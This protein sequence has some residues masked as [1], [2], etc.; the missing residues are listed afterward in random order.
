[1]TIGKMYI[2]RLLKK[3][4]M[5]IWE[6]KIFNKNTFNNPVLCC[7]LGARLWEVLGKCQFN[8]PLTVFL[9]VWRI[10]H[11][12]PLVLYG[13]MRLK[14]LDVSNDKDIYRQRWNIHTLMKASPTCLLLIY[15]AF[16]FKS[17]NEN[18][19]QTH[20]AKEQNKTIHRNER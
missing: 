13:L 2:N 8:H 4:S 17:K 7:I 9:F 14:A 12:V 18:E 6:L 11:T 19:A 10:S 20:G 3:T 16:I 5:W 1:M 15:G